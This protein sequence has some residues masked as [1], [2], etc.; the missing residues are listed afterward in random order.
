VE[1]SKVRRYKEKGNAADVAARQQVAEQLA[2][3]YEHKRRADPG[4][5]QREASTLFGKQGNAYFNNLL[6]SVPTYPPVPS[7]LKLW[8]RATGKSVAE[9]LQCWGYDLASVPE[10]SPGLIMRIVNDTALAE[11]L[12]I[13][14][15]IRD[16][17]T[18][19]FI[20]DGI[21]RSQAYEKQQQK[22]GVE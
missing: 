16:P 18:V 11:I 9:W 10:I 1:D 19:S 20:A 22:V 15:D 6:H 5:S 21:R 2:G 7:E 12:Q 3:W 14:Y 13:K 4:F 17:S 8:Q